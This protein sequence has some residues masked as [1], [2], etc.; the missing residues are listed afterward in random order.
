[1]GRTRSGIRQIWVVYVGVS[2]GTAATALWISHRFAPGVPGTLLMLLLALPPSYLAWR[3][4]RFSRMEA[5][6]TTLGAL[7]D[8]LADEV[9]IR[10]EA[11]ATLRRLNDPQPLPVSWEPSPTDL[12]E[13]WDYLRDTAMAYPGGPPSDPATWASGPN[14]L[15]GSDNEIAAVFA[16][17]PTGRLIV[18]GEPGA[19]KTMLLLRLTLDLLHRRL[20]GGP[21]TTGWPPNSSSSNPSWGNPH[22]VT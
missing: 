13:G 3:D 11:E 22:Q 5:D 20:L 12:T 1:M 10:W 18:V 16:K 21:S 2:V 8:A 9:R 7:L 15:A 4:F 6:Q 14:D 19:G 17:V